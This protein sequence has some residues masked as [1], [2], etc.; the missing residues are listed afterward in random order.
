MLILYC[1]P[2]EAFIAEKYDL[3][4]TLWLLQAA[5]EAERTRLAA[6]DTVSGGPADADADVAMAAFS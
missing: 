5:A 1:R 4:Y 2:D 6:E 3:A